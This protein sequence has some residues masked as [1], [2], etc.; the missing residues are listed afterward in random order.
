MPDRCP[1]TLN[2]SKIHYY[3]FLDTH[4]TEFTWWPCSLQGSESPC[5][6]DVSGDLWVCASSPKLLLGEWGSQ[7][8]DSVRQYL[9]RLM[10]GLP[11]AS[12]GWRLGWLPSAWEFVCLSRAQECCRRKTVELMHTA[13]FLY[14]FHMIAGRC[15][16]W[17]ILEIWLCRQRWDRSKGKKPVLGRCC[18]VTDCMSSDVSLSHLMFA[19]AYLEESRTAEEDGWAGFISLLPKPMERGNT[20]YSKH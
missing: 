8:S 12:L 2:K 4:L 14:F 11:V 19:I 13:H 18:A 20:C 10:E 17:Q 1:G 5:W 7:V 15:D 9:L 6:A 16:P 3:L